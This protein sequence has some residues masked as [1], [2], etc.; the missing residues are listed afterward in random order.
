MRLRVQG[1]SC[2]H[3]RRTVREA[4]QKVAPGAEVTVDLAS[5]TVDITGPADRAAVVAAIRE[6]GYEVLGE[7]GGRA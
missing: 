2:E 7:A 1:M 5:G 3:C 4:V 6:A